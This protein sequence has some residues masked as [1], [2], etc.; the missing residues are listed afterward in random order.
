MIRFNSTQFLKDF[1]IRYTEHSPNVSQ[2]WM[3]V[4]CPFCNDKSDHLGIHIATGGMSC[5]RCGRHSPLDYII[6]VL[7]IPRSEAKTIYSR[8]LTKSLHP[9]IGNVKVQYASEVTLPPKEFTP[10]E[11]AYLNKRNFTQHHIDTYDL[12]GGRYFGE[13]AYRIVIPIQYNNVIVSATGRTIAD[14]KPKYYSLEPSKSIMNLKH[15]FFGLDLAKDAVAVVEGPIDAI[16]GGPG[17]IASFG[18]TIKDE[19]L[20]LL[21]E[22]DTIYFVKDNDKA[23]E[24]FVREAYKLSSMGVRNVEVVSI[25]D[26]KDVGEMPQDA[27][28]DLRKELNLD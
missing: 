5:W 22:Y 25:D 28:D 4:A 23:G 26:Y 7:R 6:A 18:T 9:N 1:K 20:L 16:K 13:W 3:G 27:I 10:S 19:Q 15:I 17:F 12:R 24:Q 8:Y 21:K 14:A 2:G 11:V